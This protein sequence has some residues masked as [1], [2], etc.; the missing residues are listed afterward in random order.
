LCSSGKPPILMPG[1]Q[2]KRQ[3]SFGWRQGPIAE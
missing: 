3:I 1:L 2:E